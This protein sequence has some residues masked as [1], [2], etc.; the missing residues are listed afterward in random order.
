ME[1][2]LVSDEQRPPQKMTV[3]QYEGSEVTS[4]VSLE[5]AETI[6]HIFSHLPTIETKAIL[7]PSELPAFALDTEYKMTLEYDDQDDIVI[8]NGTETPETFYRYTNT[9]SSGG[10]EGYVFGK[11]DAL[12]QLMTAIK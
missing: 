4:T 9:F 5:D 12:Y 11:S 1:L 7:Y 3:N 8:F 6:Q 10:E 2:E